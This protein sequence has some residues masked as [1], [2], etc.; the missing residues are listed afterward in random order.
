MY[1]KIKTNRKG[2]I[3]KKGEKEKNPEN[4]KLKG[5]EEKKEE[6]QE[7]RDIAAEED[8]ESVFIK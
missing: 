1:C 3:E 7:K 6:E 2:V 4:I 8:L 5:V